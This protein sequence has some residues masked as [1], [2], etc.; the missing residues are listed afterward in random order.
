[1]HNWKHALYAVFPISGYNDTQFRRQSRF[2]I[3]DTLTDG[4]KTYGE[5]DKQFFDAQ[6]LD[7]SLQSLWTRARSGRSAEF[8]VNKG[9]LYRRTPPNAETDR[10]LLI[11]VPKP[12]RGRVLYL[13]HNTLAA[14]HLGGRKTYERIKTQFFWP[15]M[16]HDVRQYV[17]T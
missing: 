11:V 14:G 9:L 12:Y 10:D 8:Y 15:R 3:C 2:D 17:K 6:R 5:A 13:S 16:K 7:P 1:M 4:Q